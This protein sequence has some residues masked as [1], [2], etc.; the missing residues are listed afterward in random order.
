MRYAYLQTCV[1]HAWRSDP[2]SAFSFLQV[3]EWLNNDHLISMFDKSHK[4]AENCRGRTRC[5]C[6]I[7]IPIQRRI[8]EP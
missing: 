6:Y 5:D 2:A 3:E 7:L 1:T 4:G 8:V